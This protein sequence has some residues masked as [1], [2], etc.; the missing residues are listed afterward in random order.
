MI[1]ERNRWRNYEDLR[2]YDFATM[3]S[4]D[5]RAYDDGLR[6]KELDSKEFRVLIAI[7]DVVH[8]V[9]AQWAL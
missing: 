1:D 4:S 5:A 3:D 9:P 2:G 7:A 8:Y 6:S